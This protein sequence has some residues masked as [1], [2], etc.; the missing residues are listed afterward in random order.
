MSVAS[1]NFLP[2]S[3]LWQFISTFIYGAGG[4]EF[5]GSEI[6]RI[7]VHFSKIPGGGKILDTFL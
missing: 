6:L 3:L 7:S 5:A 4:E 2:E 1:W